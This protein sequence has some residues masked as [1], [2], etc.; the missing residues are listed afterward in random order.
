MKEN[1]LQD[2]I[3]YSYI[4]LHI[5]TLPRFLKFMNSNSMDL[6][7]RTISKEPCNNKIK[8][9]I[10]FEFKSNNESYLSIYSNYGKARLKSYLTR[11]N[12][13]SHVIHTAKRKKLIP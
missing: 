11:S 12:N 6:F 9:S 7:S 13:L 4:Y 10:L 8:F 3:T 5:A 1:P 2:M